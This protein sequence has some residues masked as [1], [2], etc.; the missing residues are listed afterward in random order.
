MSEKD[1][2]VR[3]K[4]DAYRDREKQWKEQEDQ[5]ARKCD[6][7]DTLGH[8]WPSVECIGRSRDEMI[9]VD[10]L[11]PGGSRLQR[12]DI[13]GEAHDGAVFLAQRG[14]LGAVLVVRAQWQVKGDL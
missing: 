9:S 1:R 11:R 7:E 13:G 12:E 8:Q 14:D 3:S 2:T 6:V 10:L 5:G 4:F